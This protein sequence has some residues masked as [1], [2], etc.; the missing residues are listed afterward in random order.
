MHSSLWTGF[1]T[2]LRWKLV[3]RNGH[4][5]GIGDFKPW[6]TS[7]SRSQHNK[8]IFHSW[9]Y[10]VR[11]E[12]VGQRNHFIFMCLKAE[13]KHWQEYMHIMLGWLRFPSHFWNKQEGGMAAHMAI[14]HSTIEKKVDET[15]IFPSHLSLTKTSSVSQSYLEHTEKKLEL[16]HEPPCPSMLHNLKWNNTTDILSNHTCFSKTPHWRNLSVLPWVQHN[17]PSCTNSKSR[18]SVSL[19]RWD[20]SQQWDGGWWLSV[21]PRTFPQETRVLSYSFHYNEFP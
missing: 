2:K 20:C 5:N 1:L 3:R 18:P 12:V 19:W 16:D 14:D 9:H 8:R 17:V 21:E 7:P 6:G 4:D 10:Q 11:F 13:V 15:K